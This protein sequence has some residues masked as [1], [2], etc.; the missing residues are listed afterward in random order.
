MRQAP[1]LRELLKA[2]WAVRAGLYV[3]HRKGQRIG[4]GALRF[5]WS[6][7][8]K[9]ANL[10][11]RLVHDLRRTAARDFRR[12]GVSEGEIMRLCGWGTRSMVDRYK[13]IDEADLASAVGRRFNGKVVAKSEAPATLP[14]SLS[15]SRFE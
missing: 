6:R 2:R 15:S 3:F 9:R 12:A 11:G 7:A 10:P 13:V 4:T 5:A 14:H 1:E 8:T